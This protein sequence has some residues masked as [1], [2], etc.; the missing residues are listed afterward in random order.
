MDGKYKANVGLAGKLQIDVS[1]EVIVYT[2]TQIA[3]MADRTIICVGE[4]FTPSL[5]RLAYAD[6]FWVGAGTKS[7]TRA[8]RCRMR[9]YENDIT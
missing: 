5:T 2:E 4:N 8:W 3:T 6:I 7:I 9:G 1:I